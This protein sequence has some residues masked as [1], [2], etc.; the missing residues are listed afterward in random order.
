MSSDVYFDVYRS[1]EDI[2]DDNV[3]PIDTLRIGHMAVM[4]YFGYNVLEKIDNIISYSAVNKSMLIRIRVALMHA[5]SAIELDKTLTDE[6]FRC[7]YG[8]DSQGIDWDDIM[9]PEEV[10]SDLSPI[11]DY[12]LRLRWD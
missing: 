3:D 12:W 9:K 8:Y 6:E 11:M 4:S 2:V 7:A 10:D 1:R 5:Q